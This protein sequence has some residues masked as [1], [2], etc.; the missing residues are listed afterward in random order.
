MTKVWQNDRANTE[1]E[2]ITIKEV[3]G[4]GMSHLSALP[5]INGV[6]VLTGLEKQ[7][8]LIDKKENRPLIQI[9]A[10][11]LDLK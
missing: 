10:C 4:F 3:I 5:I 8:S 11:P 2:S 1:K 6:K 7:Q 9:T